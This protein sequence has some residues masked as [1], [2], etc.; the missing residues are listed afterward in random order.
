MARDTLTWLSGFFVG[1]GVGMIV[2][3]SQ[4]ERPP[5]Q[6]KSPTH[7]AVEETIEQSSKHYRIFH[8]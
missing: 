4:S 2:A 1:I 8:G 6:I 3:L 7:E 5:D